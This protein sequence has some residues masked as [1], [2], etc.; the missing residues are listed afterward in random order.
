MLTADELA[1][2][3]DTLNDSLAG[4]AI[5]QTRAWVSDGGGGGTTSWTAAG[6]FDCR[7]TPRGGVED[8]LGDKVH[9]ET[10]YILTLPASASVDND[11]QVVTGGGTFAVIQVA[12]P[13]T[14]E[15]STRVQLKEIE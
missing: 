13:R 1:S 6:T 12:E 2:M 15:V 10:E 7:I 3:R 11:Q 14:W 4:T 9:P 5:I 8:D